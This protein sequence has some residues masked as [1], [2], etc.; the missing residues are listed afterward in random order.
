MN[1]EENIQPPVR[2]LQTFR[3]E[4]SIQ[5]PV[6]NLQTFRVEESIQPPDSW[7]QLYL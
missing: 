1:S 7:S 2:N 4:E 5:P 6:R 3:V